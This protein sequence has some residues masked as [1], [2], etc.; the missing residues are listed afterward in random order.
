MKTG[1]GENVVVRLALRAT[2]VLCLAGTVAAQG[3]LPQKP[4]GQWSKAEVTKILTDSA[5]AKT[6][7]IRIQRRGQVRS[8]AGQTESETMSGR[9][10]LSSAEDPLD[11]RFTLRLHSALPIRQALVR[12]EQLKWNYDRRSAAEQKAFDQQAR[13]VLLDCPVCAENYVLSVGFSSTN[14]SGNDLIYKWFGAATVPSIKGYVYLA[15]E[16]GGRRDLLDFIPPKAPGDDVYFVFPR[17]DEKGEPLFTATDKKLIF[18]MSDS[19]ANAV[20]NFSLDLSR[21]IVG[22]EVRF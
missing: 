7:A 15:N 17:L 1:V 22:G 20:T 18:R 11:Y 3:G 6:Q 19:S 4:F 2:M 12:Q 16:R 14:S 9:G 8:I 10:E 21:L 5:W 13:Q